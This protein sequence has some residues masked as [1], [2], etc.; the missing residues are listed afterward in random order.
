MASNQSSPLFLPSPVAEISSFDDISEQIDGHMDYHQPYHRHLLSPIPEGGSIIDDE[1]CY[2]L[3]DES[4]FNIDSPC[5]PPDID[6]NTACPFP[7]ERPH[8]PPR[9]DIVGCLWPVTPLT[10]ATTSVPIG[11]LERC[12][13]ALPPPIVR[14]PSDGAFLS[15]ALPSKRIVDFPYDFPIDRA[16]QSAPPMGRSDS[17][18]SRNSS[19]TDEVHSDSILSTGRWKRLFRSRKSSNVSAPPSSLPDSSPPV[20][21]ESSTLESTESLTND[22]KQSSLGR[23]MFKKLP[24][25][26][27]NNPDSPSTSEAESAATKASRKFPGFLKL[28]AVGWPAD[29]ASEHRSQR[30][31]IP[32]MA[33]GSFP[34]TP[35]LSAHDLGKVNAWYAPM[36]ILPLTPRRT[37]TPKPPA[38]PQLSTFGSPLFPGRNPISNVAPTSKTIPNHKS[39]PCLRTAQSLHAESTSGSKSM[40]PSSTHSS[41]SSRSIPPPKPVP[42]CELPPTPVPAIVLSPADKRNTIYFVIEPEWD[43]N[44]AA[45]DVPFQFVPKE[46]MPTTQS[47]ICMDVFNHRMSL[48]PRSVSNPEVL[49]ASV[50]TSLASAL[51]EAGY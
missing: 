31:Q 1:S 11:Y 49:A 21:S 32:R 51:E 47:R 35:P 6:G 13:R 45:D 30:A 10:G 15:P 41:D 14:Q 33:D 24:K 17:E 2:R 19:S 20:I 28:S 39:T 5:S 29:S 43:Q 23:S 18:S 16:P 40:H 38:T 25:M 9:I 27:G 22:E 7:Q 46:T 36:P 44:P 50:A 48:R 42:T 26:F 12:G 3:D 37:P 8:V 4:S 34:P